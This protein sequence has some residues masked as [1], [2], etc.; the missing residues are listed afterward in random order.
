MTTELTLPS[1]SPDELVRYWLG[2][3]SA[4]TRAAYA[5]DVRAFSR[6]VGAADVADAA[7]RL[8]ALPAGE[9]NA[10]ALAWMRSM[11]DAGLAPATVARRR[12]ALVSLV[13]L[14]RTLGFVAWT[15]EVRAPKV[16]TVVRPTPSTEDVAR[17]VAACETDAERALVA[18]AGQ[19]GFRRSEIASL[20]VEGLDAATCSVL[21]RRK[22]KRLPVL[23]PVSAAMFSALARIGNERGAGPL[24]LDARGKA[25]S[26]FTVWSVLRKVHARAGVAFC[27]A[28]GL[29][30]R[31]GTDALNR[32]ETVADAAAF[33]GHA[34]ARTLLRHYDCEAT[35][36]AW[37]VAERLA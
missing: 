7:R 20:T 21:V 9:A 10:L 15:L 18:L 5:K 27:G 36:R 2:G 13:K 28:H 11:E 24:F 6:F 34:D 25:M 23:E 30:R 16:E 3:V 35:R 37:D 33:M 12:S 32:A 22:G 29:R 4:A 14:A 1:S 26:A 8:F 31:A 19:R 17:L